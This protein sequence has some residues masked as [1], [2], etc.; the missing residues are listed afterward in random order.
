MLR[1][2]KSWCFYIFMLTTSATR[3]PTHTHTLTHINTYSSQP[4]KVS[5]WP[6]ASWSFVPHSEL[7]SLSS[8]S[9]G[10]GLSVT[11]AAYNSSHQQTDLLECGSALS[12]ALTNRILQNRCCAGFGL[13]LESFTST[14]GSQPPCWRGIQNRLLN[15]ERPW[16]E[17]GA[18]RWEFPLDNIDTF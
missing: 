8:K 17:R 9:W 13:R 15:R 12:L 11:T 18:G 3:S 1:F 14:L 4:G 16:G 2:W 5:P 6:L 10:K 7:Y